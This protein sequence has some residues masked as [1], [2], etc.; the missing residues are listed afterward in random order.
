MKTGFEN[1]RKGREQRIDNPESRTFKRRDFVV[2]PIEMPDP[3]PI[4]ATGHRDSDVGEQPWLAPLPDPA[5]DAGLTGGTGDTINGVI[6]RD[7]VLYNCTVQGTIG[8][9]V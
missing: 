4:K 2:P 1:Y 5:Q 7:G 9:E 3:E 8:E 6:V